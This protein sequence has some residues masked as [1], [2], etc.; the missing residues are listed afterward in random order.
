VPCLEKKKKGLFLIETT[1]P[2]YGCLNGPFNGGKQLHVNRK[3][4]ENRK[5]YVFI[6]FFILKIYKLILKLSKSIWNYCS[7]DGS[8]YFSLRNTSK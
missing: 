2:W 7:N 3:D 5:K 6:Y 8:K 4:G 1:L